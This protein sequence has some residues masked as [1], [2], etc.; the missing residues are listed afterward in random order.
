MPISHNY[1]ITDFPIP[2]PRG[3]PDGYVI[4]TLNGQYVLVDSSA[5]GGVSSV[6]SPNSTISFSPITGNV[7]GDIN[8]A[9]ENLWTAPI[10]AGSLHSN[11]NYYL[12]YPTAA[13]RAVSSSTTLGFSFQVTLPIT[14]SQLS[15]LY[16]TGNVQDHPI[17]LWNNNNTSTPI[18]SGT[19][20][21]ASASD[22]HNMKY[23]SITPVVL[24]P[25]QT[26][27]IGVDEFFGGDLCGNQGDYT[28][29]PGVTVNSI[30]AGIVGAFA[31][32]GGTGQFPSTL[33]GVPSLP[34]D[35][36]GMVFTYVD[37]SMQ[38]SGFSTT[39]VISGQSIYIAP[40][41]AAGDGILYQGGSRFLHSFGPGCMFVGPN[42]GNLT[43]TG[44]NLTA[45][46][47][48]AL[49]ANTNGGFS[50]AIGPNALSSNQ[51]GTAN[52][53]IGPGASN[54]IRTS[55]SN[56]VMGNASF[57]GVVDTSNNNTMIGEGAGRGN[58]SD[59][60]NNSTYVGSF[61]GSTA[62]GFGTSGLSYAGSLGYGSGAS[63]SNMFA[64]G[65][66]NG[67]GAEVDVILGGTQASAKLQVK[68]NIA[69]KIGL[70]VN[71][72]TSQ[73]A[74]LLELQ[75]ISNNILTS[76]NPAG[77]IN[78]YKSITTVGWGI[79]A[80]YGSGRST[81]Q[82]AAVASVATYT[83]GAADGSFEISANA[84]ITAFIAGTFNIQVD[85]T[86]ETN[87]SRTLTLNFSS[88]TGTIGI[89]LAAAGPFEGLVSHIRCKAST[90][91][92]VKTTGTFTSLTYNVE[93]II[94][95]TA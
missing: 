15:R 69:T 9:H 84:N 93:T 20:L 45:I 21:A 35:A 80:I 41:D 8:L 1:G 39:G 73:S 2:S 61:A 31:L 53:A 27:T 42:A 95:Q 88:L 3:I 46:G 4:E 55:G 18:A 57:S 40:T 10:D 75:D 65:A 86:D 38:A 63:A 89:A 30:F 78:K 28:A 71:G 85:Y 29:T 81:A 83:C 54:T 90:A 56:V 26:Y 34:Y 67:S 32:V 72:F 44:S 43:H 51:S 91:I 17:Y 68:S 24:L 82:T 64:I 37:T 19:V 36:A 6:S 74:N 7:L 92:T 77:Q 60:Y 59:T 87:S 48:G 79:P 58:G 62:F 22:A 12:T 5:I 25:G 33:F 14:V 13:T 70:V 47:S 11:V 94:K 49:I 23:V 52:I 50:V 16:I 76:A 66:V